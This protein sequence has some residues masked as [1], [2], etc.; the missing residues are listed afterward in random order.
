VNRLA[1]TNFMFGLLILGSAVKGSAADNAPL[2][3][4]SP[5]YPQ[6]AVLEG[7]AGTWDAQ[8]S[9]GSAEAFDKLTSIGRITREW[10]ADHKFVHERGGDH[11]AFFTF[12]PQQSRYRAWYFHANGHVWELAGRWTGNNTNALS[13]S[14]SLD[15]NQTIAR[16]FQLFGDKSHEC[17]VSWTDE[18]G[19]S[20]IYGTLTFTRCDPAGTV[21]PGSAGKPGKKPDS[22]GRPKPSPPAEMKIF[23]DE[24]GKW[25]IESTVTSGEKTTKVN[26]S[27]IVQWILDGQFLQS[28]V[29]AQGR[30]D[31]SIYIAGFDTATK[32]YR[33][34]QFD[35]NSVSSDA[36]TGTWDEKERTMAWKVQ[37]KRPATGDL[38]MVSKKQWINRDTAKT[39]TVYSKHDGSV[40]TTADGTI[41]RQKDK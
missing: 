11:E 22:A 38:T 2:R 1:L 30:K 16:H 12:D 39:H 24:I 21:N 4:V 18:D 40:D 9:G 20:G 15:H 25:A 3:P 10:M 14:A 26:G 34:W 13:L 33:R 17:T 32:T 35:A 36:A 41:T 28:K 29:V 23:N 31:E 7:L 27:S 5:Q 37:L 8:V 19:R 6:Y